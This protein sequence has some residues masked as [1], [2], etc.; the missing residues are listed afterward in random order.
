MK[1]EKILGIFGDS[2]FPKLGSGYS[3]L[4]RNVAVKRT[5]DCLSELRAELVYIIPTAGTCVEFLAMLNMLEIPYILVIPY[6]DFVNV[7]HPAYKALL[8][9]AAIDAKNVVVLD[10]DSSLSPD[11]SLK[12]EEAIKFVRDNSNKLLKVYS[13]EAEDSPYMNLVHSIC[14]DVTE[15][16]ILDFMYDDEL[17]NRGR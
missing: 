5:M 9:Q 2:N 10:S 12:F 16:D 4:K 17:P 15:P 1:R 6:K 14:S 3:Q 13:Y 11:K 8:K 7:P